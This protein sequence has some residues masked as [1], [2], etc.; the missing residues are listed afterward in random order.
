MSQDLPFPIPPQPDGRACPDPTR[1]GAP[2]KTSRA[3]CLPCPHLHQLPSNP[4]AVQE[5]RVHTS[6]QN[7]VG[8][9]QKETAGEA[10]ARGLLLVSGQELAALE[11]QVVSKL[12][13]GGG[14]GGGARS[15]AHTFHRYSDYTR[16]Y[17]ELPD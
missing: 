12:G 10:V 1:E 11:L 3:V 13:G 8:A 14:G 17:V 15:G 2:D 7:T 6:H 4:A 5:P 9:V 16:S